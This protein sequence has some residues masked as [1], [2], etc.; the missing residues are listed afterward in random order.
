MLEGWLKYVMVGLLTLA[1]AASLAPRSH[2]SESC[3]LSGVLSPKE[4]RR[5][6][7]E[8]REKIPGAARITSVTDAYDAMT[9]DRPYRR[10]IGAE[11]A[12]RQLREGRG[13]QF[14]PD[15]VE[16]FYWVEERVLALAG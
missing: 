2:A 11:E 13:S 3:E 7:N 8:L 12:F 4:L 6:A 5:F 16:A 15:V 10:A 14:A 1:A 9:H